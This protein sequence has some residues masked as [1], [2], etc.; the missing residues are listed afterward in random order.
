MGEPVDP[1][2]TRVNPQQVP[3]V[4]SLH[5]LNPC[6]SQR[7]S[8]PELE[9]FMGDGEL[10]KSIF[11]EIN[12][13]FVGYYADVG[14]MWGNQTVFL[15][16]EGLTDKST[17][18]SGHNCRHPPEPGERNCGW[19]PPPVRSFPRSFT[20]THL[21]LLQPPYLFLSFT[22]P[23]LY[24]FPPGAWLVSI[25]TWIPCHIKARHTVMESHGNTV[26]KQDE[27]SII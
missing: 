12:S 18:F 20:D 26:T 22:S 6:I 25:W 8:S 17:S 3:G 5:G 24:P 9:G 23:W 15:S 19:D 4:F 11:L 2:C 27:Q 14:C 10:W 21:P 13:W 16:W 1:P 7:K